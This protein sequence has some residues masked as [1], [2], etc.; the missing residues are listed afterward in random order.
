MSDFLHMR[1]VVAHPAPTTHPAQVPAPSGLSSFQEITAYQ[2]YLPFLIYC[3]LPPS[4]REGMKSL[5]TPCTAPPQPDAG[6]PPE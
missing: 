1:A 6:P 5:C 4:D 2:F 3:Y